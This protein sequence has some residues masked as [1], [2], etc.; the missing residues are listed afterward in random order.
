VMG[1][2]DVKR[3]PSREPGEPQSRMLPGPQA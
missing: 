1:G 2:V 3:K